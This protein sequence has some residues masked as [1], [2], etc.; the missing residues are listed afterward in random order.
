MLRLFAAV[1]VPPEIG[2][3]LI[4][5]QDGLDAVNW[6][7]S[8]SFHITLRY[9]GEVSEPCADDLDG[10]LSGVG[11][12]PFDLTLAGV[13]AFGLAHRTRAI[14]AGVE[15]NPTLRRLAAKCESAAR[16]AGLPSEGRVFAPHVTLAYLRRE[17]RAAVARWEVQHA[18][19]RT[20]PFRVTWFGL[21]SSRAGGDYTLQR[22][23]PLV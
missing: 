13:G 21:Y 3:E 18:L 12:E 17:D 23:Y 6:R 4:P 14:W 10:E 22:T 19:L 15:P 7:D 11:V 16:R 9:F 2:E 1:E 20:S 5:H 8:D